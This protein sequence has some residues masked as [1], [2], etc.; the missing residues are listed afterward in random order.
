[1]DGACTGLDAAELCDDGLFCTN[2]DSCQ[3]G[4]CVGSG[5]PCPGPDGDADCSESCDETNDDCSLY[6]GDGASCDDGLYCTAVDS[7]LADVCTGAGDPC[8]GPNGDANCHQSCSEASDDCSASVVD[9]NA[10]FGDRQKL[11]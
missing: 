9:M 10:L 11:T 3:G 6:D 8:P 4:S 5:S 1:M 2:V 7:C